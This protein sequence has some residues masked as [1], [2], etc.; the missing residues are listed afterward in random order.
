MEG[1]QKGAGKQDGKRQ[2]RKEEK[3]QGIDTRNEAEKEAGMKAWKGKL[4]SESKEK[5][6]TKE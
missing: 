2:G 4:E 1:S 6:K 5:R 3:G